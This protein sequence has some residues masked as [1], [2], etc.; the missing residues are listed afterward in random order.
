MN[1]SIIPPLKKKFILKKINF[2]ALRE[3]VLGRNIIGCNWVLGY[4]RL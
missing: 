4:E 2:K 1:S 3:K